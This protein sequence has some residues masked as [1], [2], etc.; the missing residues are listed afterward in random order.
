MKLVAEPIIVPEADALVNFIW[1]DKDDSF[2]QVAEW[3]VE[4]YN[5]KKISSNIFNLSQGVNLHCMKGCSRKLC[6]SHQ[7]QCKGT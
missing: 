2:V 3:D 5:K 7:F 4:N 6:M 1:K